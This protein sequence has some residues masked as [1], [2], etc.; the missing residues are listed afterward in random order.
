M[1]NLWHQWELLWLQVRLA[2]LKREEDGLQR[3]KERLEIEKERHFRS[4]PHTIHQD[5]IRDRALF[6]YHHL[7][8]GCAIP[9]HNPMAAMSTFAL[10]KHVET[11]LGSTKAIVWFDMGPIASRTERI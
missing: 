7:T 11:S 5:L 2:A 4:V 10:C 9:S 3:E 8:S 6:S 1:L